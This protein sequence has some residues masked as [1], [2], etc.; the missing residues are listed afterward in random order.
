MCCAFYRGMVVYKELHFGT[1]SWWRQ[2]GSSSVAN[3][4]GDFVSTTVFGLYLTY[5]QIRKLTS[6]ILH[7]CGPHWLFDA[8]R[9][10]L[11]VMGML[12]DMQL[13]C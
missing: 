12:I 1:W 11:L 9:V 4:F 2:R 13:C 10:M 6:L 7:G 5:A 3:V 8:G